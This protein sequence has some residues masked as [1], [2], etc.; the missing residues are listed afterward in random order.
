ME[1]LPGFTNLRDYK[2]E[3]Y[4]P[5][6]VRAAYE[7][8]GNLI[9]F[10]SLDCQS[11]M[12]DSIDGVDQNFTTVASERSAES[13]P[14]TSALTHSIS[15][16]DKK[17]IFANNEFLKQIFYNLR[18]FNPKLAQISLLPDSNSLDISQFIT[19]WVENFDC[20]G[21]IKV[22]KL[23]CIGLIYLWYFIGAPEKLVSCIFCCLLDVVHD[24]KGLNDR[25]NT[26]AKDCLYDN[27]RRL[28]GADVNFRD[29]YSK[30]LVF[31]GYTRSTTFSEL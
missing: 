28:V 8:I 25:E 27:F 19:V 11:K 14:E 22:R 24:V 18:N 20:I 2:I 4:S 5:K 15:E 16:Q 31:E 6:C 21:E 29:R 12:Q 26:V 10:S 17:E 7:F 1:Y 13:T 3:A 23:S 30:V 9:Y